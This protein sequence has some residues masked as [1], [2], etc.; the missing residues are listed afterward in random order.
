MTST[1]IMTTIIKSKMV[2]T[3]LSHQLHLADPMK[4]I[5]TEDKGAFPPLVVSPTRTQRAD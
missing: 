2:C 1:G 4:D 5:S 3:C